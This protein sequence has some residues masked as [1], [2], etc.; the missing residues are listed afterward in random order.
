MNTDVPYM[1]S[2]SN[3]PKIL[4][5]IQRGAVPPTFNRDFLVD[6]GFTS[7]QDRPIINLLKYLGLLDT[8]GRPQDPYKSFVDHTKS[9]KVLAERLA[10]SYD[11]L[12]ASDKTAH[13]KTVTQL[14]GWFKT[15]TGKGAAVAEKMARTFKTL[16]EY[17]D[18]T[19]TVAPAP[20]A[21]SPKVATEP[22][23]ISTEH[24]ELVSP[25]G[26]VYRIEVH[27]PETQNV[28]TYRAIFRALREELIS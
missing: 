26:L 14:T 19:S 1:A 20:S 11:D 13:T 9:K 18:F 25:L 12:Y 8:S 3:L 28:E 23:K 24:K 15:K 6:L 22:K 5:A 27:L 2:V 10:K 21:E 7:S 4:D 17:S 16:A